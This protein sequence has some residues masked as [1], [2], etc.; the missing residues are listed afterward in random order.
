MSQLDSSAEQEER[1]QYFRIVDE[2]GVAF[3]RAD[4]TPGAPQES[5]DNPFTTIDNCDRRLLDVINQLKLRDPLIAELAEA[6]NGK[7]NSV[8]QLLQDKQVLVR[9]LQYQIR[10]VTVSASGMAFLVDRDCSEWPAVEL[11]IQLMPENIH[12]YSVAEVIDC[13]K[14]SEGA[15][16][17]QLEFKHLADSDRELLI[18]YVVRRQGELLRAQRKQALV[19]TG[20]QFSAG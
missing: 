13:P 7:F 18:Q 17:L 5:A 11:A 2:I 20:S 16:K 14:V 10:A 4:G 6:L 1:R 3:K 9:Q 15:Y 12:I 8:I 19:D